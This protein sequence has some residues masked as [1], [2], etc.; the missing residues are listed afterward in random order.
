[1]VFHKP[2]SFLD[3]Y[4]RSLQLVKKE[5]ADVYHAH[6]LNTLPAAYLARRQTGGMVIY[7]SHELY[8][9]RNTL[10]PPRRLGKYSLSRLEAFLI[11]RADLVITVNRAIAHE[12]A[13]RYQISTP[14]VILNAPSKNRA[15][16]DINSGMNN[17]RKILNVNPEH[18]LLLYS[19]SI[20]FGRGLEKVIESLQLL[21]SC[22]FVMLGYGSADYINQLKILSQQMGVESQI[23][24]FGPVPFDE[25]TRYASS[26]DLGIAPIYNVC[27]SY[28][29]C[30]PNKLFE[31]IA[32]GLPVVGSNFPELKRIIEG[33][34]IGKTFN[35]EGPKD[36]ANA[37][38]YVLSD[39]KRYKTMKKN[40]QKAAMV[41]NWEN[42]S[43]KLLEI[44]K[45]LE[46]DQN[47]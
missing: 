41:F 1:M 37:I 27:L 10:Q 25:V 39:P 42:E 34:Q 8:L 20:T 24:L 26:A 44:Y 33:Y 16:L 2:L 22:H 29:F 7:D 14:L 13:Q 19:G 35:P 17:L 5:S 11:R 47:D 15:S 4:Y 12:L 31:Y 36:I 32:A 21:P 38:N 23:S 43:K 3:Y 28:F 9:E 40:A 18:Q 45:S 30:S 6:D 46:K